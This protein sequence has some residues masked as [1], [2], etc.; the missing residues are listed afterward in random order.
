MVTPD[1]PL[2]CNICKGKVPLKEIR[3]SQDGTKLV[4]LG[5]YQSETKARD[6]PLRVAQ[7]MRRENRMTLSTPGHRLSNKKINYT[8]TNCSYKFSRAEGFDFGN[9]CPYCGKKEYVRMNSEV[10]A[11]NLLKESS[12]S[13]LRE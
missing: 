8:C 2:R 4:C 3:Y 7:P 1:I 12:N 5:C 6:S 9:K 13:V 10:S 11:E